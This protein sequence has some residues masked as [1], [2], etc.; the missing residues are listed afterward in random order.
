MDTGAE[1]G[2]AFLGTL[3]FRGWPIIEDRKAGAIFLLLHP[4][5]L[6]AWRGGGLEMLGREAALPQA[7]CAWQPLCPY[8][9]TWL[10]CLTQREPR[11]CQ[12]SQGGS[13]A[14]QTQ[15]KAVGGRG[16]EGR[17]PKEMLCHTLKLSL[18]VSFET[19]NRI[20]SNSKLKL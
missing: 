19:R 5:D 8:T 13:T 1:E 6:R 11:A 3:C 14:S 10:G 7:L 4:R 15:G 16:E 18:V 12:G 2:T 20:K 17:A 9:G